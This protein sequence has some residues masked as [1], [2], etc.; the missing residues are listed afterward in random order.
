MVD[1]TSVVTS[2]KGG[3]VTSQPRMDVDPTTFQWAEP[4]GFLAELACKREQGLGYHE[5]RVP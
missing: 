2:N 1:G 5:G 3:V 4:A